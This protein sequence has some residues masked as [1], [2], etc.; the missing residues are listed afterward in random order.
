MDKIKKVLI[1]SLISVSAVAWVISITQPDVMAAAMVSYDP[2]LISLFTVSWT[3]G[4]AAMMFT[5]ISPMV[6]LYNKL[7]TGDGS[8]NAQ[9][10]TQQDE[11]PSL[12]SPGTI[13]FVG[14]YLLVWALTGIALLLGWSLIMNST[15]MNIAEGGQQQSAIYGAI[16]IISGFYQFSPI[17]SKCLGYCESPMSFFMRR[18]SNGSPG[19]IR[20]GMYHGMYCFGCCWP[21][22]MM[23]VAL[24]W[25]N[26]LWMALFAAIIFGEKMWSKGIWVARAAGIAFAAVGILAV[27]GIVTGDFLTGSTGMTMHDDDNMNDRATMTDSNEEKM[28]SMQSH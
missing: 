16:L 8:S 11:K 21:Y 19:A 2:V 4:M 9:A 25:M 24:V 13:L 14:S 5:A 10:L 26:V 20:M 3:V 6:L 18:W 28:T 22:F 23:M 27:A 1:V 12:H 15:V 7:T 17:K